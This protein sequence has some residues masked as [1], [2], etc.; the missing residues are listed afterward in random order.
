MLTK[1]MRLAKD[2]TLGAKPMY[3]CSQ[4]STLLQILFAVNLLALLLDSIVMG[5]LIFGSIRQQL[6][7]MI[8]MFINLLETPHITQTIFFVHKITF[9]CEH[10]ILEPV[11]SITALRFNIFGKM[12]FP[13]DLKV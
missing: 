2:S 7:S 12:P 3:P 8:V 13:S 6:E 10:F 9:S 4:I 11:S 5:P 1:L